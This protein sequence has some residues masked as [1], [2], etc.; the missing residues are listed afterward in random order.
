[1]VSPINTNI[2]NQVGD[3]LGFTGSSPTSLSVGKITDA[4]SK[5]IVKPLNAYGFGGFIFDVEG[6]TTV[7]RRAEI[8][9]HYT[10]ANEAIQDHMAIKPKRVTLRSYV[11]ELVYREDNATPTNLQSLTRKLTTVNSYIPALTDAAQLIKKTITNASSFN[12]DNI[13]LG[14]VNKGVDL[15]GLTKNLNPPIERQ[16]QA[17]M[18]F[19]ALQDGKIP[20]SLQTPFEFMTNMLVEDIVATQ[21][22][23]TRYVSDFSITLKELRTASTSGIFSEAAGALQGRAGA[24]RAETSNNG[25]VQ[26]VEKPV[27][28]LY[29][30]LGKVF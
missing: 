9:D 11:G 26:G 4:F 2:F 21:D 12:F 5:Y 28:I 16:Q 24:Q 27:S 3:A 6:E 30:L 10:E 13:D 18:Y 19:C 29:G 22:E 25:K 23:T 17:Y 8:T 1:M 15:W 14:L 7:Q 20:V